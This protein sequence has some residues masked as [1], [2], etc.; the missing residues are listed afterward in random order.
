MI[1]K[2]KK[3]LLK[4][5]TD[6]I[7]NKSKHIDFK[8]NNDKNT[9]LIKCSSLVFNKPSLYGQQYGNML[10]NNTENNY[11]FLI[12]NEIDDLSMMENLLNQI[13]DYIKSNISSNSV[14]TYSTPNIKK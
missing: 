10:I 5:K 13:K 9:S 3:F 11:D 12:D 1:I 14:Y 2:K 8:I 4:K 6:N 7:T